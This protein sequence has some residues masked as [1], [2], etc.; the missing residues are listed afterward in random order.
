M[1]AR[2][3]RSF[4]GDSA[5]LTAPTGVWRESVPGGPIVGAYR[6]GPEA[7]RIPAWASTRHGLQ[8][9]DRSAVPRDVSCGRRV[10]RTPAPLQRPRVSNPVPDRSGFVF[11]VEQPAPVTSERG[12]AV[13]G[14]VVPRRASV[15]GPSG[16]ETLRAVV[17]RA[18]T[19][20]GVRESPDRFSVRAER[21]GGHWPGRRHTPRRHCQDSRSLRSVSTILRV[22]SRPCPIGV[23]AAG[24]RPSRSLRRL[25]IRRSS[26]RRRARSGGRVSRLPRSP[27]CRLRRWGTGR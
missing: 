23:R 4:A 13:S 11:Q 8:V 25:G 2:R 19:P 16:K 14:C 27:T 17:P 6:R 21:R 3:G 15:A 7:S 12:Q 10:S 1:A 18:T 5:A 20:H 24:F 9:R 22:F 26:R